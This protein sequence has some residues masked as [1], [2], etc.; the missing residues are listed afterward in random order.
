MNLRNVSK[1]LGG[2]VTTGV[3]G[4]VAGTAAIFPPGTEVPWWGYLV[5]FVVS[6]GV[7]FAGVWI[8]PANAPP[9]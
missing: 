9:R 5:A 8:S 4:A 2:A 3:V 1:A 6:A 7:G